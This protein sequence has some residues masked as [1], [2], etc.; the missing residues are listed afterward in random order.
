MEI[1]IAGPILTKVLVGEKYPYFT[2]WEKNIAV[3][4]HIYGARDIVLLF[5]VFKY[6]APESYKIEIGVSG[7]IFNQKRI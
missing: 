7:T 5:C 6:T 1:G 4:L 3:I 2:R